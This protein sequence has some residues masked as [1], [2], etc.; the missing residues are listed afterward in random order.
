MLMI[1]TPLHLSLIVCM[2][3]VVLLVVHEEHHLNKKNVRI[4][5]IHHVF[6]GSIRLVF[7]SALREKISKYHDMKF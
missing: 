6:Y 1:F 2:K 5:P 3:C 4:I 7:L